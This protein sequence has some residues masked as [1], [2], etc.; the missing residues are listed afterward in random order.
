MKTP[1]SGLV[2]GVALAAAVC[3]RAGEIVYVSN[4]S[5]DAAFAAALNADFGSGG[6]TSDTFSAGTSI[7]NSS[8][9]FIFIEG[10]DSNNAVFNGF[11]TSA[12]LAAE[13]A[14]VN[15]GGRL[16]VNGVSSQGGGLN[17]GF[18]LDLSPDASLTGTAIGLTS[19]IFT[20]STGTAWTGTDFSGAEVNGSGLAGIIAADDSAYSLAYAG[21]GSGY[22]MVGGLTS[23]D[24]WLPQPEGTNLLDNI[25]GSEANAVAPAGPGN[26]AVPDGASTALLLG[27]AAAACL[28][29]RRALAG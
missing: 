20:G 8:N 11:F 1:A 15:A 13:Q 17:V 16:Y 14:W 4:G 23:P 18:G 3:A 5:A 29:L 12:E 28:G 19:P 2:L 6:Y 10:G 24:S 7:F 26:P 9:S 21:E 22:I 27:V 25:I